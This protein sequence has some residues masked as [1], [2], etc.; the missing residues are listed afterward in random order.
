[1][2]TT[3]HERMLLD[4]AWFDDG[5]D[6]QEK[7]AAEVLIGL[8]VVGPD[9][10]ANMIGRPWIRD[11]LNALEETVMWSIAW[12]FLDRMGQEFTNSVANMPFL[13]TF[14]PAD[15]QAFTS[16]TE[17]M[18][19]GAEDRHFQKIW[20]HPAVADGID[21]HDAETLAKLLVIGWDGYDRESV[22]SLELLDPGQF[23]VEKRIIDMPLA[24]EVE[25]NIQR[26]RATGWTGTMDH[27]EESLRVLEEFMS[28][29]LPYQQVTYVISQ[30]IQHLATQS[31]DGRV[32]IGD[33]FPELRSDGSPTA[34]T[35]YVHEQA[36]FYWDSGPWWISEGAATFL[37][38]VWETVNEGRTLY[39]EYDVDDR[40]ICSTVLNF[41]QLEKAVTD[42]DRADCAYSMGALLFHDLHRTLG[43][44]S[45]RTGFRRLYMLS[46]H[47]DPRDECEG[48]RLNV[49]HVRAAF[50]G[51]AQEGTTEA[52]RRVI[53]RWYEGEYPRFYTGEGR[54]WIHGIVLGSDGEP[55]QGITLFL[56]DG[57]RGISFNSNPDGS[58]EFRG[59]T[60]ILK[61]QVAPP[62]G[63]DFESWYG[64]EGRLTG[65]DEAVELMSGD[66]L[67]ERIEIRLPN[68]SD[69]L[70]CGALAIRGAFIFSD[71]AL[72]VPGT[73]RELREFE[74]I[75]VYAGSTDLGDV[76]SD[77]MFT[78]FDTIE[79]ELFVSDGLAVQLRIQGITESGE[80]L[81]F[82]W[83]GEDGFTKD[84]SK[85][86]TFNLDGENIEGLEIELQGPH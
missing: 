67:L 51:N 77:A 66:S 63:C 9:V 19:R 50:T 78:P 16:L 86:I 27:I 3:K 11:G 25:V 48:I 42:L 54:H 65:V 45:F 29:P 44:L 22:E 47:D 57:D 40:G 58:F 35:V 74:Q 5:I 4:L 73:G 52:A 82:G 20:G 72:V 33:D 26:R 84:V 71:G 14:E 80:W 1:M 31:G 79:F 56:W 55:L 37:E 68:S 8:A 69:D 13:D 41:S 6:I 64:G 75:N 59:A 30:N 81:E 61:L 53:D 60:G 46:R 49:C 34:F 39:P 24:G 17:L 38:H 70:N 18:L 2:L 7:P 85:A 23:E 10:F 15:A 32:L 62:R 43:E 36:H 21:D 83:L 28:A 12:L 76:D